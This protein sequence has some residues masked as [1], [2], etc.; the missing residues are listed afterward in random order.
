MN[1]FGGASQPN[2][3]ALLQSTLL[4]EERLIWSGVPDYRRIFSRQD[5]FL[6]PFSLMWGGFAIF[7]EL[8]VLGL[9][10]D[11]ASESGDPPFFFVL[12]GVPFVLVGLYFI[13]GRFL[14]KRWVRR[15]TIYA[16]TDK[17]VIVVRD[18]FGT[19]T[20]AGYIHSLPNVSVSVD[21]RGRGSV[22]F[23]G[24]QSS[25]WAMARANPWAVGLSGLAFN[26]VDDAAAA[27]AAIESVRRTDR[28]G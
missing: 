16:V 18:A 26:D 24:S 14:V 13:F 23:G 1:Q 6:V 9:V 27:V 19:R 25:G 22:D 3:Q 8:S 28:A 5:F 17:R 11:G 2:L 7:W 21:R 15:R 20:D 10:G 12:W 4:S